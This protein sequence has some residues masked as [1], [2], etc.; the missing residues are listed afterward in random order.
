MPCRF[1]IDIFPGPW[2]QAEIGVRQG[3]EL[4]PSLINPDEDDHGSADPLDDKVGDLSPGHNSA[5]A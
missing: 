1:E 2:S 3:P 5:T 4:H